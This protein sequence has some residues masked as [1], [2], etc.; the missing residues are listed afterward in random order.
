VEDAEAA[1][2]AGVDADNPPHGRLG[3]TSAWWSH[4]PH[5]GQGRPSGHTRSDTPTQSHC[6]TYSATGGRCP[7]VKKIATN[8]SALATTPSKA[9]R[10][11]LSGERHHG[12]RRRSSPRT[13]GCVLFTRMLAV[14]PRLAVPW[15]PL[16]HEESRRARATARAG[17]CLVLAAPPVPPR[18]MRPGD[19]A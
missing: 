11:T 14:A 17:G 9:A 18:T 2:Q 6:A 8:R 16:V 12:R 1:G 5:R 19:D 13:R 15:C 10:N 7:V 3:H 4:R